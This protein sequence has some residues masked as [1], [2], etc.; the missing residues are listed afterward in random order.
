MELVV[1][2]GIQG[3]GKTSF[4]RE[5]F[6][7]TYV[8]LGLDL[9]GSRNRED[10]LLYA[11]LAARQKV[12]IDNTNP[13]AR[14]RIRYTNLARAASFSTTLYFFDVT[15]TLAVARNAA[16]EGGARVPE[17]AIF[18]TQAKLQRPTAGE[19]F[20]AIFRVTGNNGLFTVEDWSNEV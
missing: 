2:A 3:S 9:L 11:C 12:V 16:R 5:R 13:T 4:Y 17:V 6:L 18:G 10:I 14:Q 1:F 20:D 7:A 15:T 8:R 19:G